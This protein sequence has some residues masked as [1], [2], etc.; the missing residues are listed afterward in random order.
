MGRDIESPLPSAVIILHLTFLSPPFSA[1]TGNCYQEM[2]F[3][4]VTSIRDTRF[5]KFA[6]I[7]KVKWAQRQPRVAEGKERVSPG[8]G[9]P[10]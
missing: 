2:E 6:K 4:D 3:L 7:P 9:E 1:P 8:G 10:I 5:G